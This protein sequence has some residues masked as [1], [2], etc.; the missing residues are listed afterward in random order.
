MLQIIHANYVSHNVRVV[1]IIL[2]LLVIHVLVIIIQIIIYNMV[3][4]YAHI[5]VHMVNI[6][7]YRS[8]HACF[9]I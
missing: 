4:L 6:L 5:Y 9:V 1:M 8:M 3:L 2:Q 7:I